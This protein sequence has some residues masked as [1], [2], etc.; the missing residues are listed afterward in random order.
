M[1]RMARW[2]GALFLGASLVACGSTVEPPPEA[3]AG[4]GGTV[5]ATGPAAGSGGGT[6]GT[7]DPA[8]A[9]TDF[10]TAVCNFVDECEPI[11]LRG[12]L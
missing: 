1:N 7:T 6:G 2:V 4:S 3:L 5:G 12:R 11:L 10:G 9:F 8:Q